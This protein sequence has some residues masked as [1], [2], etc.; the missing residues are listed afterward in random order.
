MAPLDLEHMSRDDV[1]RLVHELRIHEIELKT[2]N[3]EL[4]RAQSALAESHERLAELYGI[5]P[6]AY[7][8]TDLDGNIRE[9]NEMAASLL[10]VERAALRGAPLVSFVAREH[11]DT[12]HIHRAGVR[13]KLEQRTCELR[14]RR[15]DGEFCEV[16]MESLLRPEK[17]E[18]HV[19]LIDETARRRAE[20]ELRVLNETL[21]RHVAARTADA[22]RRARELAESQERLRASEQ[23]LRH[24]QKMDA[25]G[26]LASGLA[27]EFNNL[28]MGIIGCT[29]MCLDDVVHNDPM[30]TVHL[31]RMREAAAGGAD[32]VHQLMVFGRRDEETGT[33]LLDEVV[34]RNERLLQKTLGDDV[35]FL[36]ILGAPDVHVPC[37]AVRIGQVLMNLAINA[38]QAMPNGGVL[39]VETLVLSVGDS[40]S[41]RLDDLAPGQYA[42]LQ[43]RDTGKGMDEETRARAFE[44]FFTTKPVGE[45]TGLGLS[46]VYGI[47]TQVGG[48][49]MIDS[50]TG[51][52][53]VVT[54]ILPVVDATAEKQPSSLPPSQLNVGGK[55]V[56]VV[57]DDDLVRAAIR[58]YLQ[59]AGMVVEEAS[60]GAQALARCRDLDRPIDLVVTDIALRHVSGDAIARE[61]E[62]LRP[63]VGVLFISAHSTEELRRAGRLPEGTRSLQKPFDALMLL[64]GVRKA[65]N[66]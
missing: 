6:V 7:L 30:I 18:V 39:T 57:E 45:G 50:E 10:G 61:L 26:R 4:R 46:T 21:E 33:A 5:A 17:G 51:A 2:Q 64:A 56:L 42:V 32:M 16:R 3:E 20:A 23:E 59:A 60:D 31:E 48:R 13:K 22:E 29:D 38:R 66:R 11:R 12:L 35:Q 49:I 14:M 34:A 40:P 43:V 62:S 52:G 63:Q 36:V 25:V 28:L 8:T 65:L 41:N 58:H 54:A 53:T 55:T 19:A 24:A 15:S 44:P 37:T 47:V 1:R 27:H 9:A